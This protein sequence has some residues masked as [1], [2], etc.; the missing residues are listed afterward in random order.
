MLCGIK[1]YRTDKDGEIS[2]VVN[3]DGKIIKLNKIE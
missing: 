1:I 2:I 3:S